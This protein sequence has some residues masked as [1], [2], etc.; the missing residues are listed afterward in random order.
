MLVVIIYFK[1]LNKHL[2]N[3]RKNSKTI[4]NTLRKNNYKKRTKLHTVKVRDN[5]KLSI[6]HCV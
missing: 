4:I 5:Y 3:I 2:I 1:S 6:F